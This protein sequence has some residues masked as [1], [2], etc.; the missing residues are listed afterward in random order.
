MEKDEP[1]MPSFTR[2]DASGID[3]RLRK[4]LEFGSLVW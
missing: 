3:S 2:V 1:G 4:Q